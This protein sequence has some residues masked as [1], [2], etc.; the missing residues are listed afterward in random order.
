MSEDITP[1]PPPAP[2]AYATMPQPAAPT[3]YAQAPSAYTNVA[4]SKN[5]MNLVSLIASISTIITGI[6]WIVGVVFGHLGL[7]AV[8]RGEADN[9]SLGLA[10]LIIGYVLGALGIL[11]FIAYIVFFVVIIAAGESSY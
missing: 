3:G 1:P 10:G 7:A 4:Q 2:P 8:K 6:G 9:R 11:A 5:W